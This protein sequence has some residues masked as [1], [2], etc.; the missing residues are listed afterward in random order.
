MHLV[1]VS[2][3]HHPDHGGIGTA[4]ALLVRAAVAAGWRVDLVTRDGE[5]HPP[6]ARIHVVRTEDE[7]PGFD[8]HVPALRRIER[9]RPYRYGL[10][11]VAAARVLE[12]IDGRPDVI[13]FTDCRAEGVVA[14]TSARVRRRFRD[15]PMIVHAH[16]PMFIEERVNQADSA[17]FGRRVYHGWERRALAAADGVITTSR[18]VAAALTGP[19]AEPA[20]IPYPLFADETPPNA[21]LPRD[22]TLLLVGTIQL[23]KGVDT[24][25]RSLGEVLRRRPA[26]RAEMVGADTPGPGGDTGR[27]TGAELVALLDPDLRPRLR[28][29]GRLSHAE[30]LAA[31][32]SA[33][34]VVA[35]SRFD[36]FGLA[37]AEAALLRRPLIVSDHVGLAEWAPGVTT[38]PANDVPALAAAQLA[39]L[40]DPRS[41]AGRAARVRDQ[42]I[43]AC[44][45]ADVMNRRENFVRACRARGRWPRR[46]APDRIDR[47]D[48][49]LR[50]IR[51]AAL[52]IDPAADGSASEACADA[53]TSGDAGPP[54]RP[55]RRRVA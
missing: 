26:A 20:V 34:L 24:W 48:R 9:I 55:S 16:T 21:T 39:I 53:R 32:R 33:R 42:L 40:A 8:A 14:L 19:L 13:E 10:F 47:M 23:R 22:E 11:A 3:D 28:L 49:Y 29:R 37:A 12:A 18:R 2:A 15:V 36:G 43:A 31:I 35:P 52:T 5:T 50:A 44:D 51:R 41:A 25:V 7:R 4:T 45:P 46:S 6:A 1:L 30:T 54:A 27:T 17:R 38:V